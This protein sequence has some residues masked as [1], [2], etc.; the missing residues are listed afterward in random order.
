MAAEASVGEAVLVEHGLEDGHLVALLHGRLLEGRQEGAVAL[1]LAE[2]VGHEVG[3]ANAWPG[4]APASR[5]ADLS[6]TA[7]TDTSW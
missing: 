6:W 1:L 7:A 4:G 2:E 5:L 3:H